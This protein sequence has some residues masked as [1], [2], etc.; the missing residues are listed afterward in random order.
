MLRTFV[1]VALAGCVT[2]SANSAQPCEGKCDGDAPL[3]SCTAQQAGPLAVYPAGDQF[4]YLPDRFVVTKMSVQTPVASDIFGSGFS[5]SPDYGLCPLAIGVRLDAA[6]DAVAAARAALGAQVSVAPTSS[7]GAHPFDLAFATIDGLPPIDL[8]TADYA[9]RADGSFEITIPVPEADCSVLTTVLVHQVGI[10][11]VS[12]QRTMTCSGGSVPVSVS[13]LGPQLSYD[14]TAVDDDNTI[15]GALEQ[16]QAA[17]QAPALLDYYAMQPVPEGKCANAAQVVPSLVP[18]FDSAIHQLDPIIA[19]GDNSITLDQ[20]HA[21]GQAAQDATVAFMQA[22][23]QGCGT[24]AD[25]AAVRAYLGRTDLSGDDYTGADN[26]VAQTYRAAGALA[27]YDPAQ[28]HQS[29]PFQH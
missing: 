4:Y 21:A 16:I 25:D 23:M 26:L 15:F 3:P 28:E 10:T 29:F 24:T 11:S 2:S 22:V 12:S 14:I 20:V 7:T 13:T 1:C 27:T 19:W 8:S 6:P 5:A 18:P 9:A 17:Q